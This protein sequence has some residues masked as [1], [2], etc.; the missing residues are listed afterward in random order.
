MA[1]GENPPIG[2]WYAWFFTSRG[3][4]LY[5]DF[6]GE[7]YGLQQIKGILIQFHTGLI[8]YLDGLQVQEPSGT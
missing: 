7:N 6:Q 5:L 4:D 3:S 8:E 2:D 1:I